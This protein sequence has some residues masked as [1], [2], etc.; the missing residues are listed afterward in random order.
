MLTWEVAIVLCFTSYLHPFLR[1]ACFHDVSM[2]EFQTGLDL[3]QLH[4]I[5]IYVIAHKTG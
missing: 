3:L 5:L 4:C 2:R 1:L